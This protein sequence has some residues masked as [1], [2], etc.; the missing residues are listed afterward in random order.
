MV[1]R[2]GSRPGSSWMRGLSEGLADPAASLRFMKW[3][4]SFLIVF[5]LLGFAL[6]YL[7]LSR[8]PLNEPYESSARIGGLPL[9][10]IG[11]QPYG[12]IAIGGRPTGVLAV[13]GVA[14]GVVA[15]GGVAVGVVALSG[16][17]VGLLAVG[18]GA[19]GWW[20][21]GGGAAGYCAFGGLAVGG[22]AYA[23]GGIALGYHEASG[24]QKERLF[25]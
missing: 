7:V 5:M 8:K 6:N 13:G 1:T 9:V 4:W 3:L 12:V 17:S 2:P 11:A 16:L 19:L 22:Y 10:S 21:L 25:G 14:V 18:G 20:A 15:F 23:G 24:R